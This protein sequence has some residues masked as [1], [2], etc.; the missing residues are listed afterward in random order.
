VLLRRNQNFLGAVSILSFHDQPAT[1]HIPDES[2]HK[3]LKDSDNRR[4]KAEPFRGCMG[5][6]IPL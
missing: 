4:G 2:F 5:H 3:V 1:F 6:F